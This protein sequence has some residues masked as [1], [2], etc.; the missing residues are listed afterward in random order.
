MAFAVALLLTLAVFVGLMMWR[1]RRIAAQAEAAV[2]RAGRYTPVNDGGIHWVEDGEG[3]PILMLHGLG[4]TLGHFTYG[5]TPLLKDRYRCIAIDRP[6]CGWS[7]RDADDFAHLTHQ[8]R[9]IVE[10]LKREGISRPLVVGHSLGGALALV[11][12]LRHPEEIS[13]LAL[14]APLAYPQP[15][16]PPVFRGLAVRGPLMRRIIG[17]TVAVPMAVRMAPRTLAA[18]F[19]PEP[20]PED[21]ALRA[22]GLL[23]LRP[24]GFVAPSADL[25]VNSDLRE[26]AKDWGS[27]TAP[28]GVLYG[29]A[30]AILDPEAQGSALVAQVPRLSLDLLEGRGHMLPITAPRETAEF[31][32]R[33]A[34]RAGLARAA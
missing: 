17:A 4:G 28:G 33:M 6:G 25:T 24:K 20:A 27:I 12:A 1:T 21:F 13:G 34:D 14:I 2:P 15:E 7:E 30:D 22:G 16:I 23:G 32:T 8:A 19:A 10:F 9:M 26:I 3:P 11:L 5:V 18:I 29:E 31:I